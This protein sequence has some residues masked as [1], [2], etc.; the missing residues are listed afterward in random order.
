MAVKY[1]RDPEVKFDWNVRGRSMETT[2]K[3]T[4]LIY[5]ALAFMFFGIFAL[6][7]VRGRDST[8]GEPRTGKAKVLRKIVQGADSDLPA[9]SIECKVFVALEMPEN[10]LPEGIPES[11]VLERQEVIPLS[12]VVR[13][14]QASWEA[15]Q[16]GDEIQ[17]IY[18]VNND[19]TR[20][21]ID[22]I[23]LGMPV[24]IAD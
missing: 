3:R 15:V 5:A 4:L 14:A 19:Y 22:T 11:S 23:S 13:I 12:E 24:R 10:S 8:W 17:V 20:I 1:K 21:R 7:Y 9:Y 18:R 2:R 16:E 6:D